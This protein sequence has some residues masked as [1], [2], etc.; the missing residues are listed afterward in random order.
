LLYPDVVF[1]MGKIVMQTLRL[2]VRRLIKAGVDPRDIRS[3]A[4]VFDRHP[5][6]VVY[7][8]DIEVSN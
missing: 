4:L 7:V 2:P 8:G 3:I 6:G 1:G 5:T